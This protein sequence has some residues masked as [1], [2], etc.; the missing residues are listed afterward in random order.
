VP[1]EKYI[2]RLVEK[3][4]E[5][6]LKIF[7]AISIEGPKWCGKTSTSSIFAKDIIEFDDEDIM[8][9]AS[10]SFDILLEDYTKRPLLF[11]EWNL[12]PLVWDKVRRLCD[13]DGTSGNY[14]LTCSTK[15][16]DEDE[17][18]KIKHSGAGRIGKIEMNTMSLYETGDSTGKVSISEL[19]K[20]IFNEGSNKKIDL[21]GLADLI[22]RGGWP[23]NLDVSPEDMGVIPKNYIENVLDVDMNRDK[24]RSKEKM[25]RLLGCIARCETS[26]INKST[27]VGD[28]NANENRELMIQSRTTLDDYL[29][30]LDRLHILNKQ[31]SYKENYLSKERLGKTAKVHLIDTSLA[32]AV[33]KLNQ[34]K[35]VRDIKMFGRLF[36]S[37]VIHDLDIYMDY[38]DGNVY[39]FH[40]NVTGTEADV[41]LEFS[42]GEYAA[43][44]IKL[45]KDR[46]DEAK[47]SLVKFEKNMTKKPLFKA[48]IVGDENMIVQDK[49]TGIYIFPITALRP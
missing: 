35:I 21:Y 39:Y 15:L 11:D 24:K 10:L 20:G 1:K 38:L 32:C 27:L 17:K 41:I 5:R 43:I 19:A 22:V 37:L 6:Y 23:G 7:G 8:A 26:P 49:E 31:N 25:N 45:S 14:L 44:E 33:L 4:M 40:D 3:K 2:N 13:K 47:E 34:E 30:V 46:I 42:D 36:E 48:I 9:R 16:T 18:E 28:F 29:D 12:Y